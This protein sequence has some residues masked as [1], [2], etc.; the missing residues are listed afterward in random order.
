MLTGT[1]FAQRNWVRTP[2]VAGEVNANRIKRS[3][4]KCQPNNPKPVASH[5]PRLCRRRAKEWCEVP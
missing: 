2:Q 4:S 3:T 5:P 1:T